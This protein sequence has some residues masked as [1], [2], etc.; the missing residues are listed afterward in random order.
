[1]CTNH[2]LLRPCSRKITATSQLG[3]AVIEPSARFVVSPEAA[4]VHEE[5]GR[6]KQC[7]QSRI[8][9][10]VESAVASPVSRGGS[11]E[12]SIQTCSAYAHIRAH[13]AFCQGPMRGV[14]DPRNRRAQP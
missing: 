3:S 6:R 11:G 10:R 9:K 8:P 14:P 5:T 1:M 13:A 4:D 7:D 12:I 2:S